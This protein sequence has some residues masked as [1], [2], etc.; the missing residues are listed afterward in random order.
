MPSRSARIASIE[1]RSARRSRRL[2]HAGALHV[3]H[4]NA[5]LT[6]PDHQRRDASLLDLEVEVWDRTLAVDLRGA[7]LAASTPSHT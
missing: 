4:N 7:M 6:S 5:A 2:R 3:L 1:A